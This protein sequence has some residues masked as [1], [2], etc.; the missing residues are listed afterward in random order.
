M[1]VF[2][3]GNDARLCEC[4][5]L[6][7][8]WFETKETRAFPFQ[9][10][11]L[12]P[13]PSRSVTVEELKSTITSCE[14]SEVFSKDPSEQQE[15]LKSKEG[16][17]SLVVGY[18]VPSFFYEMD[19]VEVLDLSEDEPFLWRNARLCAL[20]M[21]G[22]VLTEHTRVPSDLRIGVIGYGRIGTEVCDLFSYLDASLVVFT[23]NA[24]MIEP[25]AEK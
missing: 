12:L 1:H 21:L 20:G 24:E 3:Y 6:L 13:I 18:E 19:D 15:N 23:S 9:D 8:E 4:R 10:I 16:R 5:R 25:L 17:K 11:H 7:Y 14:K 22:I 2:I